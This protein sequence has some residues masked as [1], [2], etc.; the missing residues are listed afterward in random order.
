LPIFSGK[1][2]HWNYPILLSWCFHIGFQYYCGWSP[3]WC[4][5]ARPFMDGMEKTYL[6]LLL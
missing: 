6:A 2:F 4:N 5:G 3:L 1:E